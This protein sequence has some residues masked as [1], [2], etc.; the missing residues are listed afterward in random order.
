[1][2]FLRHFK[3]FL[4]GNKP[5]SFYIVQAEKMDEKFVALYF[6]LVNGGVDPLLVG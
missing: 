4:L 6:E 1:M 2:Y 5:L 3:D